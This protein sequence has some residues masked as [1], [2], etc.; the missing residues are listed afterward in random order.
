LGYYDQYRRANLPANLIQ[1]QR[2]FFGGKQFLIIL[3]RMFSFAL[4]ARIMALSNRC[5]LM[6]KYYCT[7]HTFERVGKSTFMI[8]VIGKILDLNL[9]TNIC[10]VIS[11]SPQ[12][13]KELSMFCVSY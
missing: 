1:G 5:V 8:S 3:S 13:K 12:T 9:S 6:K 4:F 7:G 11:C 10:T 2:D